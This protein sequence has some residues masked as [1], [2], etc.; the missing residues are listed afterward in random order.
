MV[1]AVSVIR[2]KAE[3]A[4]VGEKPWHGLGQVLTP[5]SSLEVWLQEAGMGWKLQRS[6]VRFATSEEGAK[7]DKYH[8]WD[9]KHVLF[10]SDTKAPLGMVSADYKMVQPREVLEFFRDLTTKNHFKL[11]TA[12]TLFGGKR[13]WALAKTG[14]ELRVGGT[15]VV[16]GYLLLATSCDGSM[17][18]SGRFT[19]VRVVCNNTLTAALSSG[20]SAVTVRHSTTFSETEMKIELGVLDSAWETFSE[21]AQRLV[22]RKITKREALDVLISVLGDPAKLTIETASVGREKALEAQPNMKGMATIMQLFDGRAM[23]ANLPAAKDTAWGLVNATTQYYDH[24]HA[25]DQSN[26]LA[27]A[28]FGVNEQRKRDVLVAALALAA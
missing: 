17:A 25:R 26:R 15:D 19:S 7:N 18:T 2:G 24:I 12:G 23:G 3:M 11:E 28:W 27:A 13:Y 21:N 22:A 9:D 8:V 4:Y 1:A 16:G 14:H 20:K 10:R 6:K 5:D